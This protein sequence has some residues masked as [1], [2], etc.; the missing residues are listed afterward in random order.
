M[1]VTKADNSPLESW[2]A[3][4]RHMRARR[5]DLLESIQYQ[6][7]FN[8]WE[9]TCVP[10]YCHRNWLAAGVSWLRLFEAADLAGRVKPNAQG[11]LDF[12][13]SVGELAHIVKPRIQ[14]Y[15]YIEQNDEASTFLQSRIQGA[16]RRSLESAPAHFYDWVF[17]IDALEHN[18]NFAELLR[19][20]A[21]KLTPGG[22][23]VLSGPTENALY[24]LGRRIAG[25]EGGYHKT[26]IY[27]I[28]VAA[29]AILRRVQDTTI[30]PVVS[31]FRLSAW[32][33]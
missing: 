16:N 31:L 10:S 19:A 21:E 14:H 25:F 24:R 9:E 33:C 8:A 27:E 6:Q 26:T 2:L 30:P 18:D 5:K 17:A 11:A 15:D 29:A 23:L 22:V 28:E 1:N 4:F 32:T 13:A 20:L 7:A 12:G 3:R